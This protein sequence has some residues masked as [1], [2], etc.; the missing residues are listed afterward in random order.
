MK[1]SELRRYW[2]R[3]YGIILNENAEPCVDVQFGHNWG[4]T[5]QYPLSTI[6][7]N[8]P[9]LRPLPESKAADVAKVSGTYHLTSKYRPLPMVHWEKAL[10]NFCRIFL[11]IRRVLQAGK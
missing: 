4:G 3:V 8:K 5:L 7:H 9:T 1:W 6:L 2:R 10:K 11:V